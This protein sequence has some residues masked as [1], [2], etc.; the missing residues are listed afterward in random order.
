MNVALALTAAYYGASVANHVEVVALKKTDKKQ[1][2]GTTKQVLCGATVRDVLTGEQ[3]D[4]KAKVCCLFHST[5]IIARLL[6]ISLFMYF[7]AL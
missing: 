2:D 3:W 5:R 4:V 7:R 1:P 6:Q